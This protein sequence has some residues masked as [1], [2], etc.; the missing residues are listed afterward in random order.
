MKKRPFA[1]NS[2]LAELCA[3]NIK[4][5][6][7]FL[8]TFSCKIAIQQH[9]SKKHHSLRVRRFAELFFLIYNP[10]KTAFGCYDSNYQNYL[11]IAEVAR[12]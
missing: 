4:L 6:N 7:Y 10:R 9:L 3:E 8:L 2:G 11:V 12:R 1:Q 5:W